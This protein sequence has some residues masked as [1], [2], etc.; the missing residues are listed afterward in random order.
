MAVHKPTGDVT[1]VVNTMPAT[2]SPAVICETA[3]L[4]MISA[5]HR[6]VEGCAAFQ[7]FIVKITTFARWLEDFFW[8]MLIASCLDRLTQKTET[9]LV[10]FCL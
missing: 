6:Y 4:Y 5:Y 2:F 7:H 3:L 8:V 1:A 10:F 9:E